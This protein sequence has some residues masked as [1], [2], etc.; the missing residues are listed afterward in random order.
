MRTF[1][2]LTKDQLTE[3]HNSAD[4]LVS[5][6]YRDYLPGRLFSL[7]LTRAEANRP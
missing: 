7:L 1:S 5:K 3:A 2:E 4:K 6:K